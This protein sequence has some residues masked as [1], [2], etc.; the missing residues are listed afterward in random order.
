MTTTS[1]KR[2]S[3]SHPPVALVNMGE[4]APPPNPNIWYPKDLPFLPRVFLVFLPDVS[5]F[6]IS[7]IFYFLMRR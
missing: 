2:G 5:L 7:L 3:Y 6:L 4:G 1:W